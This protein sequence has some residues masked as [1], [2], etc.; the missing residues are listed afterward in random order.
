LDLLDI[1]YCHFLVEMKLKN[2]FF[3]E[4][5]FIWGTHWSEREC[6]WIHIYPPIC[7]DFL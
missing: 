6:K 7:F 2:I 1:Y 4:F 3:I 5:C